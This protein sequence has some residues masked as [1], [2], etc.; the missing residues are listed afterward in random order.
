MERGR[1]WENLEERRGSLKTRGTVGI[2]LVL[3]MYIKQDRNKVS[4]EKQTESTKVSA[5]HSRCNV[6]EFMLG[7]NMQEFPLCKIP[8]TQGGGLS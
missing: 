3:Q 2:F 5:L 4:G 1:E 6:T 8:V 7:F